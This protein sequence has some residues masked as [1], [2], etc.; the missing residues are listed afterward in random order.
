MTTP[1][2]EAMTPGAAGSAGWPRVLG[3]G[4]RRLLVRA[5][6][7]LATLAVTLWGITDSSYWRDE[8]ATLAAVH[9]SFSQLLRLLGHTDAVH[10]VYYI[11]MWAVVRVGGSGE[12]VTRFPSALAMA[13]A[14]AAVAAIACRLVSEPAGLAAGLAF[15][16]MPA[17]SLYAQDARPDACTAALAAGATYLL[18][19]VL[20]GG[21]R[22]RHWLAAYAACLT[23]LGLVDILCLL[24]IVAHAVPVAVTALRLENRRA[25]MAL[26]GRWL[27]VAAAAGIAVSPLAWL[28]SRQQSAVAWIRPPN[29][30]TLP[31]LAA[32]A[33][34]V[35][36]R[37]HFYFWPFSLAVMAVIG[38]GL[39][40]SL[41][42]G[43]ALL[44]RR[45][46]P[47]IVVL[48]TAWLFVPV[49]IM[50]AVS[51]VKPI[52]DPRYALFCLPALALLAG[53]AVAALGWLAGTAA[54]VLLTLVGWPVQAAARSPNGHWENIRRAD[55][56]VAA[57]MHRGDVGIFHNPTEENWSFA[58]PYGM[59][60]LTPVN[61]AES[62]ARSGTLTGTTLPAARV[63]Q[64]LVGVSRVWVVDLKVP[65]GRYRPDATFP[66]FHAKGFRL[67][68]RWR[69]G[70]I[71][72]FLYGRDGNA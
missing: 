16:I 13:V 64:R 11:A 25:A 36:A 15:A 68:H 69:V 39:L 46:P 48:A 63:R 4:P 58:Y 6:P 12:L 54:L 14:T 40:V 10:G 45:F 70:D 59:A 52:Y 17:V 20:E 72:L 56:I 47:D 42:R 22:S 7:P 1:T 43:R 62:P 8:A 19:R 51:F 34:P 24:L 37:Q 41:T 50:L 3:T 49:G 65:A 21:A 60:R 28:A 35:Q 55:Q 9:R 33:A 18:V 66:M 29:H 26:A 67:D 2:S 61:E 5:V 31:S 30:R 38:I 71:L 53:T 57:E 44:R 23:V 27:A 32:I